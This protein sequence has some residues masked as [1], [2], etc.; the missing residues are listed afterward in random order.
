ML[1]K[2]NTDKILTILIGI[3]IIILPLHRLLTYTIKLI[4]GNYFLNMIIVEQIF[5]LFL[6]IFSLIYLINVI[7]KRY[8]I[9]KIDYL[10]FILMFLGL[11]STI[12]AKSQYT[13]LYGN[14]YR[15]EGLI[16]IYTYIFIFLNVKNIKEEKYKKIIVNILL[17]MGTIY[18]I[19]AYLQVFTNFNFIKKFT[20]SYM[21]SSLCGNPNFY[22]SYIVMF[23]CLAF[24]LYITTDKIIYLLLS[25]IYFSGLIIASST[26]PFLA[27]IITLI[28]IL[29]FFRKKIKIRN[30]LLSILLFIMVFFNVSDA[31][32]KS[33]EK[34]VID[35]NYNISLEI[36][37]IIKNENT[38]DFSNGRIYVWKKSLPL[39]KKY[40]LVGAGYDNFMNVYLIRNGGLVFDKAHN[41]YL[42]MA[43]CNGIPYL[44]IYCIICLIIFLNGFFVKEP[45]YLALYMAFVGYSIQAFAN[46]N[47]V[48]VTWQ[49]YLIIGLLYS[50]NE[51][52]NF[53]IKHIFKYE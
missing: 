18:T 30:Y 7:R 1:K 2:I 13:S 46:I 43:I 24:T 12:F 31:I 33:N 29:V 11:L 44:I 26:G 48:D 4:K 32:I 10:A 45:M 9:N 17:F 14:I 47:V 3:L 5:W 52:N 27:V 51:Y 53:N 42:E 35:P 8:K 23:V 19:Y 22:G 21:G 41:I 15:Y 28:F 20:Y 38:I 36:E 34:E 49:F 39:L 16:S 25:C 37:T 6:P 50:K 40:W